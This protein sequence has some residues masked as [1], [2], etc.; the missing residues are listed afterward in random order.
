MSAHYE[1]GR[2][3]Y[4]QRRYDLAE[5]EFRK[6]LADDPNAPLAHAM[7]AASLSAQGHSDKGVK[8]AEAAI[9]LAPDIAYPYYILSLSQL[10]CN[11]TGDAEK[12]I[13]EA[14]RIDPTSSTYLT[15]A[16]DVQVA[17]E[18]WKEALKFAEAGLQN[19]PEDVNCINTRAQVLVRLNR[20]AE[21][22][23]S[24]EFALRLDPEDSMTHSNMGWVAVRRGRI[25]DAI[26]HFKEALR[27]N[28]NSEWA[29]EGVVEALKARNPIYHMLLMSS[30]QLQETS[31]HLRSALYWFFWVIPPLR[32][33]LLLF[34]IVSFVTKTLFT[35]LLRLDPLGRRVLTD[36]TKRQNNA[37]LVLVGV[38]VTFIVAL[39]SQPQYFTPATHKSVVAGKVLFES[40]D[41]SRGIAHWN[42][43]LSEALKKDER[44]VGEP[45]H[46]HFDQAEN[47]IKDIIDTVDETK[48]ASAELKFTYRMALGHHFMRSNEYD[49]AAR[50]YEEAAKLVADLPSKL[51]HAGAMAAAGEAH[52]NRDANVYYTQQAVDDLRAAA[53]DYEA[54]GHQ[55]TAQFNKVLKRLAEALRRMHNDQAADAILK[56]VQE[57]NAEKAGLQSTP[58]HLI[59]H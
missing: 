23:E 19:D 57:L 43:A 44:G 41:T 34:I 7:L 35:L 26:D 20:F 46:Y 38:I 55:H 12:T 4:Q 36:K 37:A 58:I 51:P 17:K 21:A 49:G 18:N 5:T 52:L 25:N 27:L 30:L 1:K 28:P 8:E 9:K 16:A 39:I 10:A 33:A 15:H 14:L 2:V 54:E 59:D 32:A 45:S 50:A 40:G 31:G 29:Y 13:K 3:L 11:R 53:K 6:A 56:K 47:I 42:Q 24:L 22:E 48:G